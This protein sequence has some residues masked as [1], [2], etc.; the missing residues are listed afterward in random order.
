MF[1]TQVNRDTGRVHVKG[2]P[3][4]YFAA[5]SADQRVLHADVAILQQHTV[6]R[7]TE[8]TLGG[9]TGRTPWNGMTL[10]Y[11]RSEHKNEP[12]PSKTF[13]KTLESTKNAFG[14]FLSFLNFL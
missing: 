5:L 11:T 3:D 13:A 2:S 6:W 1:K 9:F 12:S 10:G 8:L 4:H 14:L 7:F